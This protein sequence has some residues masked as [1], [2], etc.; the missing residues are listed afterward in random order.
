METSPITSCRDWA[1]AVQ[2][3][4]AAA[5]SSVMNSRLLMC[6]W[7]PPGKRLCRAQHRGRLQSCVRPV[8]AVQEDCWPWGPRTESLLLERDR[9]P[10]ECGRFVS[11]ASDR[12]TVPSL[13]HLIGDGEQ[14]RRQAESKC[15]GRVEVDHELE[16][17]RLHDWQIAGL[18]V[19]K[20]PPGI[21]SS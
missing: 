3:H 1:A 6:G 10:K 16:L 21:D 20:N 12:P 17:S 9:C 18:L 4:A 2:G 14:P 8:D 19:L 15:I 11:V 5:P 7:P 13:D